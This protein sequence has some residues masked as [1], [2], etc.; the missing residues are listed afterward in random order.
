M[1]RNRPN[2]R[3]P[4]IHATLSG[5]LCLLL[6]T[7]TLRAQDL[8]LPRSSAV[9]GGV[10][11]LS[12]GGAEPQPV[13][14]FN[15]ARV[16]VLP[17]GDHWQA[18][19]G[20]PLAQKPGAARL[21]IVRGTRHES[22]PFTVR[23]KKYT[24]Q[25]LNVAPSKVDLSPADLARV[26]REQHTLRAALATFSEP[27]P[28]TL[29]MAPPIEGPRSSS[30]GLRR[31][32]NK[33]PRN[34]HSGMDIAASTG[35]PV[36]APAAGVVVDTGDYFFN[37]NTVLLDHGAGLVT[38]YCHLSSIDVQPGQHLKTGDVLG[39]VGATGRVTGPHLHFGITLNRTMVDPAL[40]LP[41][42]TADKP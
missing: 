28:A 40:F 1:T 41:A 23:A 20:L 37:G 6:A 11:I 19:V 27:P 22:I 32:F 10:V 35:V 34:P 24:T 3:V 2:A 14:T 21:A 12:I 16:M 33:Q 5:A 18:I 36:R 8:Q 29:R 31:F 39:K 9:P 42:V 4:G 25:Y 26:E 7:T 15:G 17:D 13:A 38:M 30:F